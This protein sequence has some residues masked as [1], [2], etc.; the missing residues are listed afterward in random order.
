[1]T[2]SAAPAAPFTRVVVGYDGSPSAKVAL[3]AAS[4]RARDW[5]LP[6][7]V[8][9][10]VE[11]WDLSGGEVFT[12]AAHDGLAV[13]AQRA[14]D[15][16]AADVRTQVVYGSAAWA[17][18]QTCVAGDLLVV[19][20]HGHHPLPQVVLGS[21]ALSLTTHAPVPVLVARPV[22]RWT[23]GAAV[24]VGVDGS[25]AS[26]DAVRVAA[27][28]GRRR[29]LRL[30]A[31]AALPSAVDLTGRRYAPTSDRLAEATTWLR[32]AT[33]AAQ[34]Q[35]PHLVVEHLV[36]IGR[37][38]ELLTAESRRTS[39]VVVGSRGRGA[40]RS[41]LLGSV[42]R[43]IVRVASCPVLVVRPSVGQT[44]APSPQVVAATVD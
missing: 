34:Q 32:T 5:S 11:L 43:E 36:H 40:I 25:D 35:A 2:S 15:Q 13:A 10:C 30:R 27:S 16:G 8:V 14:R 7:H 33:R 21:T 42:G 18:S 22:A 17:L 37:P 23:G 28:E 6:L 24:V 3:E 41:A 20:A 29:G 31:V 12:D 1:M 19:G 39:L 26:L 38:V 4:E 9:A 44:D